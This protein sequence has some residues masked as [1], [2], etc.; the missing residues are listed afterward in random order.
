MGLF[1]DL[2]PGANQKSGADLRPKPRP[3][4]SNIFDDLIPG[5]IRETDPVGNRLVDTPQNIGPNIGSLP[6]PP[7]PPAPLNTLLPPRS[8]PSA[9]PAVPLTAA[10]RQM[11]PQNAFRAK[12]A[13]EDLASLLTRR[14]QQAAAGAADAV[15]GIPELPEV[16][17]R[18]ITR[19]KL[20]GLAES[21]P[22]LALQIGQMQ[23]A[24]ATNQ[25]NGTPLTDHTRSIV[26]NGLQTLIADERVRAFLIED[27]QAKVATPMAD[28]PGMQAGQ[29]VRDYAADTFGSPDPN[30]D[31]LWASVAYGAGN[32]AGIIATSLPTLGVG[33]FAAGSGMNASSQYRDAISAGASEEEA[34]R[35]AGLGALVGATEAVPILR[36]IDLLPKSLRIK[37]GNR[38]ARAI[39]KIAQSAGEEAVQEVVATGLNNAIAAGIYDPDRGWSEGMGEAAIVGGILGG[40]LGTVGGARE[41]SQSRPVNNVDRRQIPSPP[42]APQR[43]NQTITPSAPT[44][45]TDALM[46]R[47]SAP[48]APVGQDA[49]MPKAPAVPPSAPPVGLTD[50]FGVQIGPIDVPTGPHL[51]GPAQA[52]ADPSVNFQKPQVP[53][54]PLSPPE[55]PAK[56][57]NRGEIAAQPP[58]IEDAPGIPMDEVKTDP[59]T[60]ESVE[61]GRKGTYYPKTGQFVSDP[62]PVEVSESQDEDLSYEAYLPVHKEAFPNSK[63]PGFKKRTWEGMSADERRSTLES[64]RERSSAK[65]EEKD[66]TVPLQ[67]PEPQGFPESANPTDAEIE[68]ALDQKEQSKEI[69]SQEK[70]LAKPDNAAVFDRV[71]D[72][73][74]GRL[75]DTAR[76]DAAK[77]R[78][79]QRSLDGLRLLDE[80]ISAGRAAEINENGVFE[81]PSSDDLSV[82]IGRPKNWQG[83]PT[84]EISPREVVPGKWVTGFDY[85]STTWGGGSAP[86]IYGQVFPS[87]EAAVLDTLEKARQKFARIGDQTDS[88]VG[89]AEARNARKTLQWIDDQK[90][91]LTGK[92]SEQEKSA[93]PTDTKAK[94]DKPQAQDDKQ[95]ADIPDLPSE[96]NTPDSKE[97]VRR[98][99]RGEE[100]S[101]PNGFSV[102]VGS[103]QEGSK[104]RYYP[105]YQVLRGLRQ[106]NLDKADRKRD[107]VEHAYQIL[108]AMQNPAISELMTAQG[109]DLQDR[110][111]YR[112]EDRSQT[113]AAIIQKMKDGYRV[114]IGNE[115]FAFSTRITKNGSIATSFSSRD[116]A[117][118][119]GFDRS[120]IDFEQSGVTS[121]ATDPTSDIQRALDRLASD[122]PDKPVDQ[123][124]K[125]E[126][127]AEK[128]TSGESAPTVEKTE[129]RDDPADALADHILTQLI[130]T[131]DPIP[132]SFVQDRADTVFGGTMAE[133]AYSM[134]DAYEAIEV[135]VN[136]YI[137]QMDDVSVDVPQ[138]KAFGAVADL[139]ALTNRLPT[140][141]RRDSETDQF[142]QF[143]TPPSYAYAVNW[144]AN[145]TESDRV[146]EPSAGNGGIAVFAKK[147]GAVVHANEIAERRLGGL[148]ALEM[149]EVSAENAEQIGN[150]W[151]NS[152]GRRYTAVV[153]NPPFSASGVRGGKNTSATGAQHIEQALALL[154]PGGRL[155]AI[156]GHTFRSNNSRLAPFY[157]KVGRSATIRANVEVNGNQIYKKYGTTYDSR[158]LVI[159]KVPDDGAKEIVTGRAENIGQLMNMLKEVRDDT[160][161]RDATDPQPPI[162]VEVT[163]GDQ[164]DATLE[165]DPRERPNADPQR[166]PE[167]DPVPVGDPAG[168]RDDGKRDA[169]VSGDRPPSSSEGDLQGQQDQRDNEP[170]QRGGDRGGDALGST[171]RT[172]RLEE[173][174]SA[175]EED[176]ATGFAKYRPSQIRVDGSKPH[177]MLLVE[178]SAMASVRPPKPDYSL[179]LPST[180][181]TDGKISE[182]QLEQVIYAG[183]AHQQMLP[184]L[185]DQGRQIRKGYLIGDGTGVGKTAEIAAIVADNWAKGRRRS[186]LVSKD[187]KLFDGARREFDRLGMK[188]I[189]INALS[190]AKPGTDVKAGNSV[191]FTTYSTLAKSSGEGKKSRVEQIVD[192]LGEDFDGLLIFD[193]AHLAGNVVPMKGK[194]GMT[195]PSRTAL[196][197]VDLQAALPNARVVYASAT[198]A[199]E[200]A[201][202]GYARR[203]GLWGEGTPFPTV[204]SFISQISRGGV[205]AME[206]VARDMKQ[207]GVYMARNLSYEGVE[208]EKVQHVL[209]NDQRQMYNV[210]A[211]AWQRV[212]ANLSEAIDEHTR[213]GGQQRGAAL[214]AFWGTHQRFFNTLL[215]S[216][217]M[218][219]VLKQMRADMDAGMSPVVQL[220]NTGEA[221]QDRAMA[222]A[223]E[224]GDPDDME[225][226]PVEALID[227]LKASFPVTQYHTV[228]DEE[229]KERIEPVRDSKGELVQNAEAVRM[230]DE[231]ITDLASINLP[232]NPL[233]LILESFGHKNVAEVTGRKQRFFVDDDGNKKREARSVTKTKADVADFMSDKRQVLVFSGAGGT[234]VDFHADKDVK[235]QRR[236]SHYVIQAGWRPDAAV[237][238]FGRTHRTNQAS[239]PVYKLAGTDLSGHKRFTSSIARRL[240]QLGALTKGQKSASSSQL[241]SADDNLENAYGEAAVAALMRSIYKREITD[242]S[243]TDLKSKMGISLEGD[244]GSFSQAKIPGVT[245]FLNRLLNVDIDTQNMLFE[246][247]VDRM[248]AGIQAAKD[249]GTY[250]DGVEQYSAEKIRVVHRQR[251]FDSPRDGSSSDYVVVE[252][253]HRTKLITIDYPRSYETTKFK[254]H[255]QT[256]KI[257]GFRPGTPLT[258]DD[259]S[260]INTYRRI[261]PEG[262]K[263][264]QADSYRF[265]YEKVQDE[266]VDDLWKRDTEAAP[267]TYTQDI[268]LVTGALLPIY[269]R[270][271]STNMTIHRMKLD[272]GQSILG[273]VIDERF[274]EDTLT[275]LGVKGQQI[276]M[277]PSEIIE[278]VLNGAKVKFSSGHQFESVRVA[279]E[280]RILVAGKPPSFEESRFGGSFEKMGVVSETHN[281]RRRFYIP[282]GEKGPEVV[283]R[284]IEGK[285]IISA[286]TSRDLRDKGQFFRGPDS[287]RASQGLKDQLRSR[288]DAIG[289]TDVDLEI[290]ERRTGVQAE[291]QRRYGPNGDDQVVVVIRNTTDPDGALSHET[292]HALRELN[293]FKSDEWSVLSQAANDTW[294]D[295]FNIK[296]RYPDLD[297]AGQV[298]EAVAEAYSDWLKRKKQH[299]VVN[300]KS[301][302]QAFQKVR[303][304]VRALFQ[305]KAKLT[306]DQVFDRVVNAEIGSRGDVGSR[307]PARE[308][309]WNTTERPGQWF[310]LQDVAAANETLWTE[311]LAPTDEAMRA[312]DRPS[313][314]ERFLD[315]LR[316]KLQ[317]RM[318]PLLRAQQRIEKA[319]GKRLPEEINAYMAEETYSGRAGHKLFR[320]E[321]DFMNP[322]LDLITKS[323]S[324]TVEKVG[325]WLYA[326]HAF[327]RNR[328]IRE[329]NPEM[330]EGGA[331]MTDAQARAIMQSAAESADADALKEIGSLIDDLRE[332]TIWERLD[333]GLMSEM[334][335]DAW[336]SAYDHYV[337]LKGFHDLENQRGSQYAQ[338]SSG[339]GYT[340]RG[341]ETKMALG[342]QST[343]FNPLIGAIV[344]AQE[345]AVRAEKNRVMRTFYDLATDVPAPSIWSVKRPKQKKVYNTTTGLVETRMEN[346]KSLFLEPNEVA[347]KVNG[348]EVRV[349]IH[350]PKVHRAMT[351]MGTERMGSAMRVLSMISRYISSIHTRFNPE[352]VV[353]NG[354]RDIQS[355][356][357]HAAGEKDGVKIGTAMVKNWRKA[358][359]GSARGLRG[360]VDTEWSK[361]FDEF[362]AA[363]GKVDFFRIDNPEAA[364]DDVVRKVGLAT[365][366]APMSAIR[367]ALIGVDSFVDRTNMAVD[368]AVRLAAFVEARRLGWSEKRAASLAK[369]ITVNFNSRGE[370][371]SFLNALYPFYNAGIQGA[372]RSVRVMKS[373]TEK[374]K[375]GR[376]TRTLI[377]GM[378]AQGFLADMFNAALS[379]E[380]D[381]GMLA[382][383]KIPTYIK[384]M[385]FLIM[386]GQDEREAISVWMP[387]V[388][389][390]FPYIGNQMS[391]LARGAVT[392]NGKVTPEMALKNIAGAIF[393]SF[394]PIQGS[395]F[396]SM[397]TPTLFDPAVEIV[398]NEN[399]FGGPIK[400]DFPND[401]RPASQQAFA[402]VS[403][404]SRSAAEWL[405]QITGGS[406]YES[407]YVDISPE[408]LDHLAHAFTGG[409]GKT[410]ALTRDMIVKGL[411]GELPDQEDTPIARRLTSKASTWVDRAMYFDR[412]NEV[413]GAAREARRALQD[414]ASVS[415]RHRRLVALDD[416]RK[417]IER[418]RRALRNNPSSLGLGDPST[419]SVPEIEQRL[420]DR[421]NQAYNSAMF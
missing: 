358:F 4:E 277:Q 142:Q 263:S 287:F 372:T 146:L 96:P 364:Y 22:D 334:E 86:S 177:P 25:M 113:V 71:S 45:L 42:I 2:I 104:K 378:M 331:G 357:I 330:D 341:P 16:I 155:V 366:Q 220:V 365:G 420:I 342:R 8:A 406:R 329:I 351:Q 109:A 36:A 402:S 162:D 297:K 269:D 291:T 74:Y 409:A 336:R 271:P 201:N 72:A 279:N 136:R 316:V 230:R 112:V 398:R 352:F 66:E 367:N 76:R 119:I 188:R 23:D 273:R 306:S 135:A 262:M 32:A 78:L 98:L 326:R 31:S 299:D 212:L 393:G 24:L 17:G 318:L 401:S 283:R 407:G 43:P 145:I 221:A 73:G 418:A 410:A 48:A 413:A 121:R 412:R 182:A 333:A 202:L 134:K 41:L 374:G 205:A 167:P 99:G 153:M 170:R 256:G 211:E 190:K 26:E 90:S 419:Y 116:I 57:L 133:G 124:E 83:V 108:R 332:K 64:L 102:H 236:R 338:Q 289:L 349:L 233:D 123:S 385:N 421:F 350:D 44:S 243:T 354:F 416:L 128:D 115:A 82:T 370:Y 276:E 176:G 386:M 192:W 242:F 114:E 132:I 138:P 169:D 234:G 309:R 391:A 130:E 122:D 319:N 300:A 156:V 51:S 363:G 328:R 248:N 58:T 390:V 75:V 175:I 255:R 19:Q 322:I 166:D 204:H 375:V 275:K 417:E 180:M 222:K 290:G 361:H 218:P 241:F 150:I 207:M 223:A 184:G 1:D 154:Q 70:I 29:A 278:A 252:A 179:N 209:T 246:A 414:G 307:M 274:L 181:I 81:K 152:P 260:V 216:M 20:E 67:D 415:Q 376:L 292:I 411:H 87:R 40:A 377:L 37:V 308:A 79:T 49:Q 68:D 379:A 198:A 185:D 286:A 314:G 337:P 85:H 237:Q 94:D 196:A 80:A 158:V 313:F 47:Q 110:P 295:R 362:A 395:D 249:M 84:I 346:P 46:P 139:L 144:I 399:F 14:G 193:E 272:D 187:Q 189:P 303:A 143:S 27:A 244:D 302:R 382:Y 405:N 100:I 311:F 284:F 95:T 28:L 264:I 397:V 126:A 392:P 294:I 247:F 55:P 105:A 127:T 61:T 141:T 371:G 339:G 293:L 296:E 89:D 164:G 210:A 239:A 97:I 206:V 77:D 245:Q 304:F 356:I 107:A 268:H 325:A 224:T 200:V 227:Y 400:P 259:G 183:S 203:L 56:S 369:N 219:T 54:A 6:T 387:Y 288:L 50:A 359:M 125:S 186:V 310:Q 281:Y 59:T 161:D 408:H 171:E 191:M 388:W 254:V 157:K 394:S 101:T 250:T 13:T 65:V 194:R 280:K 347:L 117:T 305:S 168:R 11:T 93:P 12:T 231:L 214:S 10:E 251:A 62:D 258:M 199:T 129:R 9:P 5:H 39:G 53:E 159:D 208:Y 353:R 38:F 149:D 238:G 261:G 232:G 140:Q 381:D 172:V 88:T 3:T 229:G 225:V 240:D 348:E 131:D 163:A 285:S 383:D 298:E 195:K 103:V 403:D 92:P 345:V 360:K 270:L 226:R 368:N 52:P 355:A 340:I 151:A 7:S 160:P 344:Q 265:D 315:P 91:N 197:V 174:S 63:G 253:T 60:G 30:D 118:G 266:E 384:Q 165:A 335:A 324:L 317:D 380:D 34:E 69:S 323:E 267:K 147:Q 217:Q 148:R 35:A 15:A 21:A 178:S 120:A 173:T 373:A 106:V 404:T 321:H 213:G 343:A 215:T 389:N 228:T 312:A 301:V 396:V 33:G 257:Y 137:Y 320:I 18:N 327:E 111:V 282:T 235:N